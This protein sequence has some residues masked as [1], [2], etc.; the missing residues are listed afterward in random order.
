RATRT[1][2]EA[3]N[4]GFPHSTRLL[5]ALSSCISLVRLALSTQAMPFSERA[6]S[7]LSEQFAEIFQSAQEEY[8]DLLSALRDESVDMKAFAG[9]LDA[10]SDKLLKLK[11]I[12]EQ[13]VHERDAP[14]RSQEE[15]MPVEAA[16][17]V[18]QPADFIAKADL[19]RV[20]SDESAR[21]PRE[22]RRTREELR[23]EGDRP[24][25]S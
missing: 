22:P 5:Q 2:L 16:L 24:F 4:R 23:R 17:R 1:H 21:E 14:R 10:L 7:L 9:S 8:R 3:E 25:A 6:R 19:P 13:L 18:E 11:R 12:H 20:E 15:S